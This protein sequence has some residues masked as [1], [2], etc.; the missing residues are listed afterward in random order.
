M[1]LIHRPRRLRQNASLRRLLQ[2]TR[3]DGDDLILPLFVCAGRGIRHPMPSLPGHYQWSSDELVAEVNSLR[4]LGV[5][6]VMLFGIPDSKDALGSAASRD[7]G[8]V[9]Q[10]IRVFKQHYPECLVISDLC[11]CEYT[12]HGHCGA[13]TTLGLDVDNDRTLEL[14]GQQAIS[15]ARA[16]VDIIAP[17]GMM[18]GMVAAIRAAL[19]GADFTHIPILSYAVKYSSALYGPFRLAAQTTLQQGDRKTYQ[20]DPA[21]RFEAQKEAS[22]DI[23]EGVDMLMVK[24]AHTYLDIIRDV[25]EKFPTLP[26]AAYHVSGEYAMIKAAAAQD[27]IDEMAVALEVL[28]AIKRAGAD[29]I[30]TYYAKEIRSML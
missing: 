14:L 29:F 17:S 5:L 20:M 6:G 12:D 1:N 13:L 22:L 23:A 26:L 18:D 15:H 9:Q 8:V 21:N 25:K 11:F 27:S 7:D 2:E 24:P 19:D 10:A 30:I 16:G 28:T 4:N 3:L